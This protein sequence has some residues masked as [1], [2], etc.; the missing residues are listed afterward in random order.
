[1]QRLDDLLPPSAAGQEIY[2]TPT[3]FLA[4]AGAAGLLAD[5]AA[6]RL[7]G[8]PHAFTAAEVAVRRPD[9][10]IAAVQVSVE[11]LGR[12]A[13]DRPRYRDRVTGAL[14]RLSEPRPGLAGLPTPAVMGIVNVTPDSFSDGGDRFDPAVAVAAGMEMAAAGAALV[15]VGGEST[16]PGSD[17]VPEDEEL[18]R[19]IPVVGRLAAAGVRVSIDTRRARVMR[20][21]VAAGASIVN[22]VTAL[23]GDPLSAA[24]VAD[25]GIPAV[26]MHMRGEPR[27]MQ[28]DPHYRSVVHDVYDYLAARLA[29]LE[30][31]GMARRRFAV[32][33]G[34]GFG[35]TMTHNLAI[36]RGL[37]LYLGLGVPLLVGLSR[38]AFIG[39][40]GGGAGAR[41]RL[42]GSL[43][44][45]LW[46]LQHGAT[47]L[48]VHDVGE[49]V[50][51]V[52]LWRALAE[53]REPAEQEGS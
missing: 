48:R 38:K 7:A 1:M 22:D 34:I 10:G 46:S 9:G 8:G 47:I 21:A 2:V 16:R 39:R 3:G 17:P 12:W 23:E 49:T 31:A 40:I 50:Q 13:G 14:E 30:A 18:R 43:A 41:D 28:R 25:T 36:L 53:D 33:P 11:V 37:G 6:R 32:D 27:T 24:V 15:D 20:E 45:A 5:G 42:G 51:A 52:A 26:L 29:A 19:V 4:A 35:K 44:G